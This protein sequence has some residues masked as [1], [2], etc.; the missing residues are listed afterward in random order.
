[1]ASRIECE[2]KT[3]EEAVENALRNLG[4][5]R[6]EATVEVLQKPSAGLFGLFAKKARIAVTVLEH[7]KDE[8]EEAFPVA[9]SLKE[10]ENSVG[11]I[12]SAAADVAEE[13]VDTRYNRPSRSFPHTRPFRRERRYETYDD[14]SFQQ[15]I[16]SIEEMELTEAQE[17]QAERAIS[18]LKEV[19]RVMDI[20]VHI[21]RHGTPTGILLTLT[22]ENLGILIGKHGQTL[23]SLQYLTNLAANRGIDE[24]RLHILVDVENYRARR[25]ETLIRLAG[26]LAE[27]ACRTGQEIHLEPMNRHERRIIHTALIDNHRVVT[28]SAGNEPRR[29]VVIA[30]KRRRPRYD[31]YRSDYG[32]RDYAE[33]CYERNGFSDSRGRESFDGAAAPYYERGE[34]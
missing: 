19:I 34:Y 17:Q 22:G 33:N 11:R 12:K 31:R 7:V 18:F 14:F 23:D 20:E 2:A 24:G 29:Y 16:D 1:M 13:R 10:G 30:P 27:K 25:E 6:S 4:I 32:Q 21:S 5:S 26:H 9:S 3:V 15:D 8:R 28:Y